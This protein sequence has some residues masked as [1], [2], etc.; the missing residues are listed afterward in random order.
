MLKNALFQSNIYLII[1][2]LTNPIYNFETNMYFCFDECKKGGNVCLQKYSCDFCYNQSHQT[3]AISEA[4]YHQHVKTPIIILQKLKL[5]SLVCRMKVYIWWDKTSLLSDFDD[6]CK[7][8]AK[9]ARI[10][11]QKFYI[12]LQ[13]GEQFFPIWSCHKTSPELQHYRICWAMFL[14]NL[15]HFMCSTSKI[16]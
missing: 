3:S 16:R 4:I 5:L 15:K 6:S 11:Y 2:T 14:R 8:L 1:K 9:W 7:A 10:A 13:Q 12:C